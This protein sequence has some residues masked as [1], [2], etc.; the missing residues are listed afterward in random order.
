[1]STRSALSALNGCFTFLGIFGLS[2]LILGTIAYVRVPGP[3]SASPAG[4]MFTS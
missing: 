2:I 1:M 3:E 4:L